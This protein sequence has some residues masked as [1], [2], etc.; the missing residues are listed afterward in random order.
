MQKEFGAELAK[1]LREQAFRQFANAAFDMTKIA[2]IKKLQDAKLAEINDA[3]GTREKRDALNEK[4]EGIRTTL[5]AKQEE[6]NAVPHGDV[7]ENIEKR[8]ALKIEIEQL[9]TELTEASKERDGQELLMQKAEEFI[10]SCDEAIQQVESA[11]Q[12]ANQKGGQHLDR[13]KFV[14]NYV[15]SGE[16]LKVEEAKTEEPAPQET[17]G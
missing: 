15:W 12:T 5:K 2:D 6:R 8:K 11:V 7:P 17:A 14:E 10:L 9:K 13:A 16:E 3:G 4:V 1:D